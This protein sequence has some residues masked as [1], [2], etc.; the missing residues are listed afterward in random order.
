[1]ELMDKDLMKYLKNPENVRLTDDQIRTWMNDMKMLLNGF[2]NEKKMIHCDIKPTNLLIN[3]QK[4]IKLC[5]FGLARTAEEWRE[6][7]EANGAS[8]TASW[9]N[10]IITYF[11]EDGKGEPRIPLIPISGAHGKV[12]K[13]INGLSGGERWTDEEIASHID[14]AGYVNTL[15]YILHW[16]YGLAAV[17]EPR[18]NYLRDMFNEKYRARRLTWFEK[19]MKRRNV[20]DDISAHVR[21]LI[22]SHALIKVNR[23]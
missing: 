12:K 2:N 21:Q 1:M 10:D 6:N 16:N 7:P 13:L 19:V 15:I 5:D 11:K 8:Y 4:Q 22:S 20:P 18:Q 3:S 23:T 17:L 14:N 9:L